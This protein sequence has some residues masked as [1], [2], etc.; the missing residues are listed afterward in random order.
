[1]V[2]T[3]GQPIEITA[4]N[5]GV[6]QTGCS[7]L[8]RLVD[9]GNQV[10]SEQKVNDLDIEGN[11]QVTQLGKLETTELKPALYQLE[12]ILLDSMGAELARTVDVFF[13]EVA[14]E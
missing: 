3:A 8:T 12:L 6:A 11:V 10:A 4:S 14:K 9:S 1:V 2:H 13:L 7:L 5:M